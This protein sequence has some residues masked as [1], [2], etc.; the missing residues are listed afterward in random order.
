M[1]CV[2]HPFFEAVAKRVL[3]SDD[4]GLY[5]SA[6]PHARPPSKPPFGTVKQQWKGGHIDIQ[7]TS[8]DFDAT[9]QP[10][11]LCDL[12]SKF[13]FVCL[14]LLRSAGL[15]TP[16]PSDGWSRACFGRLRWP[17]RRRLPRA[18]AAES[19]HTCSLPP[20]GR[21]AGGDRGAEAAGG[22]VGERGR[23]PFGT[24]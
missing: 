1:H 9:P 18:V 5:W 8:E 24:G 11:L 22:S 21:P 23:E 7:A 17:A 2:A 19:R 3:R 16:R 20:G 10:P 4:V 15:R 13:S 12:R 6:Q 14:F